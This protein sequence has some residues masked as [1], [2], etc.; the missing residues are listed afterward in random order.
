LFLK[1]SAIDRG[2]AIALLSMHWLKVLLMVL[3]IELLMAWTFV[4]FEVVVNG[5]IANLRVKDKYEVGDFV[6]AIDKASKSLTKVYQSF[7]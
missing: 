4:V 3:F 5:G 2:A 1:F 6:L 7:L